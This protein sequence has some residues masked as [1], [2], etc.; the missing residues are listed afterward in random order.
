MLIE[1]IEGHRKRLNQ[2]K[3][4]FF[5]VYDP[6]LSEHLCINIFQ[7]YAIELSTNVMFFNIERIKIIF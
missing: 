1:R 2:E 4:N 5:G 7:R 6:L 3:L